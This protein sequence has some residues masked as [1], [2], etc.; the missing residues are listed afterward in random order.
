MNIS[1]NIQWIL[2]DTA[3]WKFYTNRSYR[4]K[5][6]I[7]DPNQ[8]YN[9][10]G[11]PGVVYNCLEDACEKVGTNGYVVTGIAGEMWPI[12]EKAIKKYKVDPEKITSE[13]VEV[14]TV[15]LDTVY[16]AILIPKSTQFTL[17]VD[18]GEKAVLHGNRSG[19]EHGD[20]D[21]VLVTA[22]LV[23]GEYRPDPDDCGRIINGEVF[24][25]LYKPFSKQQ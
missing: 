2:G 9:V 15:E 3:S 17:E 12:G 18:Y 22:K 25:K 4:A 16:A 8:V 10:A 5:I 23:D 6:Q 13:P 20:G 14:D 24:S 21:Y 7:A 1:E 19:I 11:T